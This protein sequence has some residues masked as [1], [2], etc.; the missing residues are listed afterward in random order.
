[1]SF[2]AYMDRGVQKY[3][4]IP[5]DRMAI[6]GREEHVDF[7]IVK[8]SLISREHFGIDKDENGT[9]IIID[10]GSSN[11]TFLNDVKLEANAVTPLK[12]G[13]K[14]RAGHLNVVFRPKPAKKD[15]TEIVKQISAEYE[16]GKGF[17]TIMCEIIGETKIHNSSARVR[18]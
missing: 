17:K 12:D 9:F 7:Q 14:I 11:G 15:T 6:F 4:K 8:D 13:D 3:F 2:V 10:L 1:M 5:E 18:K 16:K